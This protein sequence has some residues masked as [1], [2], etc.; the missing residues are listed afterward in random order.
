M[1]TMSMDACLTCNSSGFRLT[2]GRCDGCF[3]DRLHTAGRQLA[4]ISRWIDESHGYV[5]I[6]PEAHNWRRLMKVVSEAGEVYDAYGAYLGENPRKPEATGTMDDVIRETLDVGVSALGAV[7]HLTANT[8]VALH[9]LIDKIEYVFNRVGLVDKWSR[10]ADREWAH[11]TCIDGDPCHYRSDE[12]TLGGCLRAPD[13]QN[14][15]DS[16]TPRC[17]RCHK[18]PRPDGYLGSPWCTE[19]Q[20]DPA[21]PQ[22]HTS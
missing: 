18:N 14:A 11:T 1:T 22:N 13:Q 16:Y 21:A 9:L 17:S 6:D 5:G 12:C 7:E 20:A 4:A 2:M 15:D 8:G 19:C 10:E 3:I